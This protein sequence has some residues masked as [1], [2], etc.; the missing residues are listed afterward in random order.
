[1]HLHITKI[2]FNFFANSQVNSSIFVFV[3]WRVTCFE[4]KQLLWVWKSYGVNLQSNRCL[5]F[6]NSLWCFFLHKLVNWLIMTYWQCSLSGS[7]F[8]FWSSSNFIKFHTIKYNVTKN[9]KNRCWIK[10]NENLVIKQHQ[11]RK[12]L[13]VMAFNFKALIHQTMQFRWK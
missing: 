9:T 13:V 12:T 10:M 2:C 5:S 3:W 6:D 11:R 1:M 7:C 8:T 4:Q